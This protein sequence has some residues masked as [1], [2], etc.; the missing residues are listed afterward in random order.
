MPVMDGPLVAALVGSLIVGG[1]LL[2]EVW[3]RRGE[4]QQVPFSERE[5]RAGSE[6]TFWRVRV[7][8][9]TS[10]SIEDKWVWVSRKQYSGLEDQ[11]VLSVHARQLGERTV[12]RGVKHWG[13]VWWLGFA[14]LYFAVNL[15]DQAFDL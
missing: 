9:P 3:V 13:R 12:V 8:V 2:F 5:E 14:T 6:D 1:W 15:I 11:R 7:K 10:H 4:V